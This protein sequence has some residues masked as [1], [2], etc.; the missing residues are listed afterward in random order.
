MS[1]RTNITAK[2]HSTSVLLVCFPTVLQRPPL[3]VIMQWYCNFL[4]RVLDPCVF[5]LITLDF[6]QFSPH[7]QSGSQHQCSL[8]CVLYSIGLHQTYQPGT[9]GL[10]VEIHWSNFFSSNLI[11]SLEFGYLPISLQYQS[12]FFFFFILSLLLLLLGWLYY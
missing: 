1:V 3:R 7:T 11:P 10:K 8:H 5:H 2:Q 4:V 9:L 12:S 6:R